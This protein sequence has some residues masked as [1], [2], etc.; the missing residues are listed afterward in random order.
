LDGTEAGDVDHEILA[1]SRFWYPLLIERKTPREILE[2]DP[3]L[4]K[5]D[6]VTN[7]MYVGDRHYLY[8]HQ[9]AERNLAKVWNKL[10]TP[11]PSGEGVPLEAPQPRVL[12]IWGTSDWMS[13]KSQ[14]T[15]IVE[16][17]NR[18]QPGIG[19]YVELDS[20]DH[21]FWNAPSPEESYRYFRPVAGL[22]PAD[23]NPVVIETLHAW[24]AE[25]LSSA[26]STR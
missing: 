15:W 21:F 23:F 25:T 18:V 16:V 3:D 14:H 8:H 7:D 2:N 11:A 10:A 12:A 20:I 26:T 4:R 17:V 22:P 5:L 6:W 13:T 24:L 19:K 1:Q 9:L